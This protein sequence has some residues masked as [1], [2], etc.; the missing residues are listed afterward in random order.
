[1]KAVD[2]EKDLGTVI[3][4]PLFVYQSV[5][6]FSMPPSAANKRC[7]SMDRCTSTY[8]MEDNLYSFRFEEYWIPDCCM[9]NWREG[10]R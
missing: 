4:G 6:R 1:M 3:Q 2:I 5:K 8:Q 7:C 9:A 10:I